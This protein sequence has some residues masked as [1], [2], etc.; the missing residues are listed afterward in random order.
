MPSRL[1][2]VLA[3]ALGLSACLGGSGGTGGGAQTSASVPLY[4]QYIEPPTLPPK[5]PFKGT[6]ATVPQT[7]NQ[8]ISTPAPSPE[9]APPAAPSAVST[10]VSANAP[11][12]ADGFYRVQPGDTV[13]GI[14]RRFGVPIRTIIEANDLNP[15]YT[16]LVDQRLAV[17]TQRVHVVE[18]GQTVYGISRLYGVDLTELTRLNDIREPYTIGVGQRLA[19]P[20]ASAPTQSADAPDVLPPQPAPAPASQPEAPQEPE[21]AA[22]P[23]PV[24][25][26]AIPSP[27]AREGGK[28]LWP[29]RGRIISSFGPKDGGLHNDGINIAAEPGASVLASENGVVVYAGNELRGFGNLLLIKH[30]DG[31]VTAYAHNERLLV[32]RGQQVRRGQA[33]AQVG[34]S[35]SVTSPQLHFEIRKGSRAINPSEMLG[36]QQAAN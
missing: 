36:P 6:G 22:I 20:A 1:L 21:L 30:A 28:F 7:N 31:W 5:N 10:P 34:Q 12:P 35:G 17:P 27:P 15:P 25:T 4:D 3:L 8:V 18:A 19:L 32:G 33:I 23:P 16:L 24:T 14:S 26:G 13:Y 29:L 11:L 9:P 2:L